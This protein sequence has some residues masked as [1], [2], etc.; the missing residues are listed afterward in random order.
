MARVCSGSA[1]HHVP[2]ER[3]RLQMLRGPGAEKKKKDTSRARPFCYVGACNRP[4]EVDRVLRG[5][6]GGGDLGKSL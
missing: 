1:T 2:Y 5:G 3:N 4:F 6:G